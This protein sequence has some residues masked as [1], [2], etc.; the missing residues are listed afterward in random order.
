MQSLPD[1]VEESNFEV[2]QFYTIKVHQLVLESP[3]PFFGPLH[4]PKV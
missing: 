3:I 2:V 4:D 1:Y